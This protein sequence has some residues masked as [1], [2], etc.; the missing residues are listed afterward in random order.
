MVTVY[1]FYVYY[2]IRYASGKVYRKKFQ[3]EAFATAEIALAAL[4]SWSR[5]QKEYYAASGKYFEVVNYFTE[6]AIQELPIE[7]IYCLSDCKNIK[8][9]GYASEYWLP[10]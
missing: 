1:R 5:F 9:Y 7:E 6:S 3:S 2:K 8:E 10:F 4:R